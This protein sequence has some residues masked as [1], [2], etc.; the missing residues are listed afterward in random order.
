M[1]YSSRSPCNKVLSVG[2]T[3][4]SK[5]GHTK[6]SCSKCGLLSWRVGRSLGC[7]HPRL[8]HRLLQLSEFARDVDAKP[9]LHV[10]LN[11]RGIHLALNILPSNA[12]QVNLE[13]TAILSA[14]IAITAIISTAIVSII[15]I[16]RTG[17]VSTAMVSTAIVSAAIV[18]IVSTS[19]ASTV[20]VSSA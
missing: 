4:G 12:A 15:I 3:G 17:I 18:S 2:P 20:V 11:V 14:A 5:H 10:H 1:Q 9:P 8:V 13:Y 16:D 19:M 6:H 7:A